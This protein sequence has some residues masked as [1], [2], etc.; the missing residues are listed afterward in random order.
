ME[1]RKVQK[2]GKS[3]LIVSLPKKWANENAIVQR[4]IIIY[5]A[6]PKW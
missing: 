6:K 2:T 1:T 4:F 3:T 5:F